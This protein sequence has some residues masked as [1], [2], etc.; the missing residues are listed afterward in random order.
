MI[1][2]SLLKLKKARYEKKFIVSELKDYEIEYLI[3]TNPF[4]FSEIF[5]QRIVNNLYFDSIS[6]ENYRDN[7]SGNSFRFKIR[8][9]WYGRVFG[10]IKKP[11]LE[12]KIKNNDLG[13]KFSFPLNEFKLDRDF[14]AGNIQ[15]VFS[16][17]KIPEELKERLKLFSPSLLNSY[18]RKYFQSKDKNYRITMDTD[19]RFFKIKTENNLFAQRLTEINKKVLELKYNYK[20]HEKAHLITQGFP[21]RLTAN[22]KYVSGIDLLDF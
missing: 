12:L 3:K 19:L 9:R 13:W 21:F 8:I 10:I 15:K 14:S 11:I 2:E 1:K 7:I 6:L 5:Y 4:L 20:N 17:S 22:S 16:K 18:K